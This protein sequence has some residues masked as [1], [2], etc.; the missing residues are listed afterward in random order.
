MQ[1]NEGTWAT[2]S[3]N[4]RSLGP[5]PRPSPRP[6][7]S[8]RRGGVSRSG[9]EGG[10]DASGGGGERETLRELAR[11][12]R[13]KTWERGALS[14]LEGG[15]GREREG[16]GGREGERGALS[17]LEGGRG[18]DSERARGESLEIFERELEKDRER[19]KERGGGAG[20][21]TLWGGG[22]EKEE[23]EKERRTVR[24]N[25]AEPVTFTLKLG[26][27]IKAAGGM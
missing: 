2:R 27:D 21:V 5:T 12:A 14:F 26:L 3:G 19:L 18:R 20:V 22:G 10:G 8:P 25:S 6:S 17:F 23:R 9:G 4:T 11:E 7:L 16:G 15:R 1:R 13:E 24:K